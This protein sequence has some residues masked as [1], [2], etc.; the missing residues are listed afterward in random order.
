MTTTC[1][2]GVVVAESLS[3]G[4]DHRLPGAVMA[5]LRA[6]TAL[7]STRINFEFMGSPCIW[8]ILAGSPS[9]EQGSPPLGFF[10]RFGPAS[11]GRKIRRQSL[12]ASELRNHNAP[13]RIITTRAVLRLDERLVKTVLRRE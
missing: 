11:H 12:G 8:L 7:T 1:L 5:M 10:S 3:F 2:M 9:G 4:C 13:R 6:V